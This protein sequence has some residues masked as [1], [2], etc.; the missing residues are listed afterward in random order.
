MKHV[1]TFESFLNESLKTLAGDPREY[2]NEVKKNV[3]EYRQIITKEIAKQ[4]NLEDNLFKAEFIV[5]VKSEMGEDYASITLVNSGGLPEK[6]KLAYE[7]AD[8][9]EKFLEKDSRIKGIEN[10]IGYNK[11]IV[12]VYQKDNDKR[13]NWIIGWRPKFFVR[14]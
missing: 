11:K 6:E 5:D 12:S 9:V 13:A 10:S 3:S 2:F 4:F 7:I 8:Y 1:K 14:K